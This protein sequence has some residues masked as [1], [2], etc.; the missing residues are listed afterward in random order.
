M[1]NILINDNYNTDMI[2][3]II[4]KN[5]LQKT[6]EHYKYNPKG[7]NRRK[8]KTA[9]IFFENHIVRLIVRNHY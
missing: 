1:Q 2:T 9:T 4:E 6:K 8:E 5:W 3:R 7:Y